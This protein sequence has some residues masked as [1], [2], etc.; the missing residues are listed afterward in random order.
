[1]DLYTI[2]FIFASELV[3]TIVTKIVIKIEITMI[4]E[5]KKRIGEFYSELGRNE[6]GR[7]LLWL[8]TLTTYSQSTVISRL[9]DDGWKPLERQ[10]IEA[11]IV[12][13]EWR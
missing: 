7:F 12:S 3:I 1:M 8:M 4:S 6:K 5:E 2:Y 11:G 13:G 9:K 10:A